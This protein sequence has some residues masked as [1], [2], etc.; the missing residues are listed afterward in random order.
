MRASLALGVLGLGILGLGCAMVGSGVDHVV[1]AAKESIDE[2][3]E[4]ARYRRWAEAAW[5]EAVAACPTD[6]YSEGYADGFQAGFIDYVNGGG[7]GEPPPLH[8]RRYQGFRY[9]TPEGYAAIEDWFGG[10]RAGA[11]AARQGPYR[12]WITG[13]SSLRGPSATLSLAVPEDPPH[14]AAPAAAVPES[15]PEELRPPRQLPPPAEEHKA[16]SP[17]AE[18]DKMSN[19]PVSPSPDLPPL[20]DAPPNPAAADAAVPEELPPPR[21]GPPSAKEDKVP[22]ARISSATPLPPRDDEAKAPSPPAEP[23]RRSSRRLPYPRAWQPAPD[24]P[25]RPASQA[26]A[27]SEGLP[28]PRQLPE[29]K[30][31][32]PP[33][34]PAWQTHGGGK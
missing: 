28:P 24:A 20:P 9:Q 15:P 1:Y 7:N 23:D 27:V 34:D 32:P 25:A 4:H 19:Q 31:P 33:A 13:P 6:G 29:D 8:P 5:G 10:Y 11:A 26:G 18:P 22:Q 2:H 30:A 16:P 12:E 3:R 21:Q 14:P 17:P